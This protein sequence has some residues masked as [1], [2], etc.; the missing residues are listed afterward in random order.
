MGPGYGMDENGKEFETYWEPLED[1]PKDGQRP[2]RI[3]FVGVVCSAHLAV[4]RG[5]RYRLIN[6][7]MKTHSIPGIQLIK[8]N[9]SK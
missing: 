1:E 9:S 7:E 8:N 5:M 4:V 2:Y 3:E 6:F